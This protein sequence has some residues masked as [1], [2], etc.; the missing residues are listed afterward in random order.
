M[1]ALLT[2]LTLLLAATVALPALADEDTAYD[3]VTLSASAFRDVENDTLVAELFAQAEGQEPAAL[4]A[5]VNGRIG[6]AVSQAKEI[7]TVKVRTLDYQT[8]PVYRNNRVDGWRVT[9]AIRLESPDGKQLSALIG[10]LQQRLSVRSVGYQVSPQAREAVENALAT[11][12]IGKF[13]ERAKQVAEAFGKN[14]YRLVSVHVGTGGPM[15]PRPQMYAARAMAM[16]AAPPT[17]EAG[18]QEV[19]VE[20][21]G[22]V[23]LR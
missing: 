21:S 9:Q 18:T 5:D 20:V 4:A 19:R 10:E 11:E 12:A 13:R 22:T 7:S 16:D 15:P 6:W 1:K 2:S 17:L 8:H 3:R 14:E 23:E